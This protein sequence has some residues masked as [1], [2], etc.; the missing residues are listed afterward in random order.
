MET[1]LDFS[2]TWDLF[3]E[4]VKW[5]R[6]FE[7]FEIPKSFISQN[8]A[9]NES[10]KM[11]FFSFWKWRRRRRYEWDCRHRPGTSFCFLQGVGCEPLR[12]CWRWM[13]RQQLPFFDWNRIDP[14]TKKQDPIDLVRTS[15]FQKTRESWGVELLRS[16]TDKV[17]GM[18]SNPG[19]HWTR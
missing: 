12:K 9:A 17:S 5:V 7:M 6:V 4:A 1:S 16:L 15:P 3:G 2:S 13:S 8:Y 18:K 11:N 10:S 14:T 19:V